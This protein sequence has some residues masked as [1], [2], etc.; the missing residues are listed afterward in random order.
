[1]KD[2]K[3][4][5]IS[6]AHPKF[7]KGGGEIAAYNMYKELNNQGYDAYFLAA[8]FNEKAHHGYTPFS[9]VNEKEI[10]FYASPMDYF[11]NTTYDKRS[12]W[13]HFREVLDLIA[14]D[15]IHFHHYMHL[16]LEKIREAHKYK[17]VQTSKDVRVIMTLHEYIA[18]CVNNGQMVKKDTNALCYE[19]DYVDCSK[20]FPERN[21]TDFFL[22]KQ[23]ILSYFEL[24]DHFV[25]PS[26]FL[27]ERYVNWGIPSQKISML[28]NGQVFLDTYNRDKRTLKE[29]EKR[30]TFG[31]FGQINPF[32]GMDVL[33]DALDYLDKE[34][35]KDLKIH[36]H[37]TGMEMWSEEFQ[38]KVKKQFKK[39]K[40]N[41]T[42]FGRYEAEELPN[43][44]AEVDWVIIPSSWWENSPLVIQESFKFGRP[45]IASN[46][47]GMAEKITDGKDGL[48]FKVRNPRS[49]A[50]KITQAIEDTELYDILYD[51]ITKP[52]SIKASIR[53]HLEVYEGKINNEEVK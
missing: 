43:L 31:Y 35:L 8:H 45:M 6:H 38:E 46:I 29:D 11:L 10:L 53:E 47:G 3:I 18:I 17:Q 37:G 4:L 44:M 21:P 16:G 2:K 15:V 20:C 26:H 24:V 1:M 12:T 5:I 52:L 40:K 42:Y 9:I 32:K 36:I 33:M 30:A 39:Y 14:P 48:H 41:V 49:L 13:K 25:S 50:N 23:H 27:I 19:S 22:R 34:T 28:E 51:G 7:S